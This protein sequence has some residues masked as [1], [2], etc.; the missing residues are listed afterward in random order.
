MIHRLVIQSIN[1]LL[2]LSLIVTSVMPGLIHVSAQVSNIYLPNYAIQQPWDAITQSFV[3]LQAASQIGQQPDTTIFQT[4]NTNFQRIFPSFPKDNSYLVVYQQCQLL[5]QSLSAWFSRSTFDTFIGNCFEPLDRIMSEIGSKFTIQA[6][7]AANPKEWSA[8]VTVTFD[9]R[10]STDPSNSTIPSNNYYRYYKDTNGID[11]MIGQWPVVNHTFEIEGT[12]IVHLTVR[13]ANQQS[14][15]IFDGSAKI[16]INVA[17]PAATVSLFAGG[18]RMKDDIIT[19][20]SSQEARAGILFDASATLAK[21]WRK[22]TSHKREITN[23]KWFTFSEWG[24][25]APGNKNIVLP[26]DGEYNISLTVTDNEKN[27]LKKTYR[28]VVSDPIALIRVNPTQWWTTA[29][30]FNFDGSAS[31]SVASS[32][33]SYRRDVIDENGDRIETL[34]TKDFKKQFLKPGPYKIILT[35]TDVLGKSNSD[36]L[37]L[38]VDSTPPVPQFIVDPVLDWKHPSQFIL[39]AWGTLDDDVV[40]GF[41]SLTYDWKFSN[42]DNVVRERNESGSR[43]IV[44]SFEQPGDYQI[45]LTVRDRYGKVWELQKTINVKSG[46][47]PIINPSKVATSRWEAINF[48]V[49]SNK[50]IVNYSRD[51]GDGETRTV[52]TNTI[53]HTYNKAWIYNVKLVATDAAGD[54]NEITKKIFIGEKNSPVWAYIITDQKGKILLQSD[55]CR[56]QPAY[57]IDRQQQF[58]IDIT[59]SVNIKGQKDNNLRIFFQPLRDDI[60]DTKQ[61]TYK[62]N[63]LWCSYIDLTVEDPSVGKNDRKRIYFNVVNALPILNSLFMTFPQ[64]GNDVG[65]WFNANKQKDLFKSW[66][67]PLV[68]KVTANTAQPADPDGT[69]SYYTWYYY[70]KDNP[71]RLLEIK[72]TPSSI[73]YVFFSVPTDPG[74]FAFWVKLTDNDGWEVKSEDVIWNGPIVIFPADS[75]TV[76]RPI[77]TL[78]QDKRI[79]DAWETVRFD[80]VTKLLSSRTDFI[81]NRVFKYDFNGD[82]VDD[83][84]TKNDSAEY[85]YTKA[86]SYKP[87]VKVV[88]RLQQGIA[89]GDIVEVK[90]AL[91]PQFISRSAGK[92]VIIKDT[93]IGTLV[94]RNLCM[95]M[96]TCTK[97]SNIFKSRDNNVA[98]FTYPDYGKFATRFDVTDDLWNNSSARKIIEITP[99][100]DIAPLL[101]IPEPYVDQGKTV[102]NVW[103][104]LDNEIARYVPYEWKWQCYID[105]NILSDSKKD[106]N[107]TNNKDILCNT[108]SVIS[109]TPQFDPLLARLTYDGPDGKVVTRDIEIRFL[110]YQ[111]SLSEQQQQ[112]IK[113]INALIETLDPKKSGVKDLIDNLN[114]LKNN[115]V[116]DIATTSNVTTTDAYIKDNKPDITPAQTSEVNRILQSLSNASSKSAGWAN[117]YVIAKTNILD[118]LPLW[119]KAKVTPEFDSIEKADWQ[120]SI[121]STALW[122]IKKTIADNTIADGTA[123]TDE[124]I[125]IYQSTFNASINPNICTIASFYSIPTTTCDNIDTIQSPVEQTSTPSSWSSIL[126]TILWRVGIIVW[127][128]L[129][130]FV[131][132]VI[133]FAIRARMNQ[134]P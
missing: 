76:D 104:N 40:N 114:T 8:P 3:S 18:Q 49:Q 72:V 56:N 101:T 16:A 58:K 127:V 95:D 65:I 78:R 14:D 20:I 7:I 108:L 26:Q 97:D 44:V 42:P 133:V 115:I 73:N 134:Q 119:L 116:D 19:K 52:Q 32:I 39:D 12:Y 89:D 13:S 24:E 92:N 9:A 67:D 2:S 55:Q 45:Q 28:L 10:N 36:T 6:S 112:S 84:I 125:Q 129:L 111:A 47:R 22:I 82:G 88:Y 96:R 51:F 128:L 64:Y 110:D 57:R 27:V 15:G 60:F 123:F 118:R 90:D 106:G 105:T 70:K 34:Q 80:V 103:A 117:Q 93:S 38:Y 121:I 53:N 69:L 21:G 37:D 66:V 87:T 132:L 100:D 130:W 48:D 41:D 61:F 113:D 5:S 31:Y 120:Q 83:L 23:G 50:A 43:R 99:S 107:T 35:T 81:A 46:L 63:D 59:D 1:S 25:F 102:I 62:F 126:W 85:I 86:W 71:T 131:I 30:M 29:T 11:R 74:E 75:K 4:L 91:K 33:R 68:V 17:P 124:N 54:E 94:S 98:I 79:I 122:N 77:V 109:Y